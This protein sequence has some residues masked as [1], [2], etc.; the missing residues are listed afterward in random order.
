MPMNNILEAY[1][2]KA[3]ALA[4]SHLENNNVAEHIKEASVYSIQAGGK[5][6]R[7]YLLFAALKSLNIELDKGVSAA[8]AVE[9]IHTYSLIHDDLPAMDND[10]YRRGRPT[11][12]KVYGE[13][14]AILAGDNLLTESFN[15][16][17]NDESLPA[18]IR[19]ELVSI[20]SKAAGQA[21]M[22]GGQMLDLEAEGKSLEIEELEKIHKHKT[23]RMI[24]APIECATVIAKTSSDVSEAL[25]DFAGY[26]GILFQIRDDILDVTGDMSVTGKAS[27]SDERKK[28]STYVSAYGLE[29][30][31]EHLNIL[32][33]KANMILD[34]LS[35]ILDTKE[36][37]KV[38]EMFAVRE[39]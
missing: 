8:A 27:G 39:L 23:G 38:L 20:I 29:G 14:T 9:M 18:E 4:I 31:T 12:H 7:P 2:H 21:G 33:N 28:K 15:I 10:D 30:A 3:E 17:S 11:N 37:H 1:N 34:N 16:L 26:L 35:A 13:A 36:L 5:R 24:I 19:L 6:F 25:I 32:R 22:I